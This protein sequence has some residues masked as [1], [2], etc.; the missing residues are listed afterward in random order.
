MRKSMKKRNNIF[1]II[2][3]TLLAFMSFV[4]ISFYD[5]ANT[6]DI[7]RIKDIEYYFSDEFQYTTLGLTMQLDSSYTPLQF[8]DEVD[9]GKKEYLKSEFNNQLEDIRSFIHMDKDFFYLAKNT[10]TQQVVTNIEG[11]DP[12]TF[13]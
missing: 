4:A 13:N 7:D 3:T 9:E 6:R 8:S 10:K 5:N 12:N 1:T 11:Y 2:L